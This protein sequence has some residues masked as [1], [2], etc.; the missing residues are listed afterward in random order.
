MPIG[1]GDSQRER[2]FDL[3]ALVDTGASITAV[4]GS[5]LHELGIAPLFKQS[6]RFAQGDVKVMDVGQAWIRV[7]G[8]EVVTMLLFNDE[9]TQ[10]LLGALALEG[11]FLGV[12]PH[13]KR[14]IPVEG[15]MM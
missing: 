5:I 13:A 11:V 15:L 12:D 10:P 7:E 3:D 2:W 14:L 8:K 9:G 6:F 1:I 4:P